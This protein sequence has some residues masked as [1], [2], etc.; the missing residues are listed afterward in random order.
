MPIGVYRCEC[1][2]V[3]HNRTCTIDLHN[4]RLKHQLFLLTGEKTTQKLTIEKFNEIKNK[5]L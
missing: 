2:A 3:I 4:K 5:I 1:G